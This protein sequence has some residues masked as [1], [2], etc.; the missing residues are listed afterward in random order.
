MSIHILYF[1]FYRKK[2]NVYTCKPN[3]SSYK[4]GLQ[5]YSLH[6]LVNEIIYNTQDNLPLRYV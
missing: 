1:E 2:N 4:D 3:F 5:G 6:G